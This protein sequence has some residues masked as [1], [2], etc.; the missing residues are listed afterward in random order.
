ML[1]PDSKVLLEQVLKSPAAVAVHD[2][3]AWMSI[4]SKYHIVEDPV[5]SNP[6]I[7]GLYDTVSGERGNGALGRFFDT[8][9][10]PNDI[11]F[12][13][14]RYIVCANH[15][16]RD[17]TINIKMSEKVQAQVPMHLLYELGPEADEWKITRLAA[18]WELMPM[19]FQLLHDFSIFDSF[20]I[21]S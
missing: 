16:V 7:G 21:L 8:F 10:A 2:K 15:V 4:F 6:H 18:Y 17:L 13:V 11:S 5:G 9:I 19:I 3:R 20:S 1:T 14:K 12:D